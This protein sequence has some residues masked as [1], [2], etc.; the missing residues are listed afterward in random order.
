[1]HQA[2][3]VLVA[4]FIRESDSIF[5]GARFEQLLRDLATLI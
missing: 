1:M 2:P 3:L 4:D 5:R